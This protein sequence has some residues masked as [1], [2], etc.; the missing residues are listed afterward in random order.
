MS[1]PPVLYNLDADPGETTDLAGDA[2]HSDVVLYATR[3]ML[4]HR[5]AHS[6][7]ELTA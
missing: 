4:S 3:Q 1:L 6:E 5:M 7:H 2:G